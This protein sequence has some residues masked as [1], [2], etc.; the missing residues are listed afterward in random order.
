MVRGSYG[1]NLAN[2][3]SPEVLS[4]PANRLHSKHRGRG[5]RD[6]SCPAG[7]VVMLRSAPHSPILLYARITKSMLHSQMLCWPG[8]HVG[9]FRVL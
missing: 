9:S 2:R 6:E 5:W 1:L 3:P 4:A 7:S 8:L